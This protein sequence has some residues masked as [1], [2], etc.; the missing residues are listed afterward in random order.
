MLD[1]VRLNYQLCDSP[2]ALPVL[3]QL[4]LDPLA[5]LLL[6]CVTCAPAVTQ[7]SDNIGVRDLLS[8]RILSL[9]SLYLRHIISALLRFVVV[10][11]E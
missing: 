7:Q 9:L 2:L 1:Q 6:S 8:V 10:G 4:L 3:I 11:S 5:D